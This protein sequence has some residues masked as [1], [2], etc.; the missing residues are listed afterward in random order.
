MRA[1]SSSDLR[2]GQLMTNMISAANEL[3]DLESTL[4]QMAESPDPSE[5]GS[6]HELISTQDAAIG[7]AV[8]VVV[9][10]SINALAGLEEG[11]ILNSN[12]ANGNTDQ[13]NNQDNGS[14]EGQKGDEE[15]GVLHNAF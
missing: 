12:I 10:E 7:A 6:T 11:D 5:T 15:P 8:E 3:E 9:Q 2:F 14:G 1:L 13:Q 4:N